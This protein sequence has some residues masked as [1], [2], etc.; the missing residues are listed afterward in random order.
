MSWEGLLAMLQLLSFGHGFFG[1]SPLP[2]PSHPCSR[3]LA[4][5]EG[6]ASF[7]QQ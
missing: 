2:L 6:I 4:T 5:I 1:L 3:T 7:T